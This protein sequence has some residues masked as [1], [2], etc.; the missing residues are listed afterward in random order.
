MVFRMQ[1]AQDKSGDPIVKAQRHH[2]EI[3]ILMVAAG[4]CTSYLADRP[5]F[6]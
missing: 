1:A 2:Y 4:E 5:M 6:R 3:L